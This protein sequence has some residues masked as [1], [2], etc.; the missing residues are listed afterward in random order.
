MLDLGIEIPE[1]SNSITSTITQGTKQEL[2]DFLGD[3]R[4]I[5]KVDERFSYLKERINDRD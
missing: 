5:D 4:N 1:T 2:L 3:E